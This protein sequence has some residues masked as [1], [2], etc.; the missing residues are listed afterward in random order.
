MLIHHHLHRPWSSC[1]CNVEELC[2]GA[3]TSHCQACGKH[4]HEQEQ[5]AASIHLIYSFQWTCTR[6]GLQAR[7]GQE[8]A[9]SMCITTPCIAES[10]TRMVVEHR[11]QECMSLN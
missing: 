5:I 2:N 8:T 4:R 11:T 7:Y 9:V 10:G 1:N 6:A 3:G